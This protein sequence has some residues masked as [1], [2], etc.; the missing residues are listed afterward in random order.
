V[1]EVFGLGIFAPEVTRATAFVEA[2]AELHG[3]LVAHGHRGGIE[4][5]LG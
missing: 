1:A 4:A 3:V 2:V 5:A